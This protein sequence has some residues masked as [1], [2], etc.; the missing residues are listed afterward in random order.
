MKHLITIYH[1][2]QQF[3]LQSDWCENSI[4]LE[5]DNPDY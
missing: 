2:D 3:N 1:Q 4:G 5:F